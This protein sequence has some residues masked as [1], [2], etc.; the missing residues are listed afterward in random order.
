MSWRLKGGAESEHQILLI[1]SKRGEQPQLEVLRPH[2]ARP[3]FPEDIQTEFPELG[4]R[5]GLFEGVEPR[6]Q[7]TST[8]DV[9]RLE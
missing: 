4:V 2:G 8:G 6:L 1:P 9:E 7:L 3:E 5:L